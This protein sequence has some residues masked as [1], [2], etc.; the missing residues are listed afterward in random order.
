MQLL[1]QEGLWCGADRACDVGSFGRGK[2]NQH[3]EGRSLLSP[4]PA[5]TVT[6]CQ[7]LTSP[8]RSSSS[9]ESDKSSVLSPVCSARGEQGAGAEG[10]R[11]SRALLGFASP[12]PLGH[13]PCRDGAGKCCWHLSPM[14]FL[15]LEGA[16][17]PFSWCRVKPSLCVCVCVCSV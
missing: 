14:P 15:S 8:G 11:G 3:G 9:R 10:R 6:Q 2:K 13:V 17:C 4:S 12:V 7:L 16:V 1:W 5:V